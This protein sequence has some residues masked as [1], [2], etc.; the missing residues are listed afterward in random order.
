LRFRCHVGHAYA[1]RSLVDEQ[2]GEVGRFPC[3][4]RIIPLDRDHLGEGD[5][6]ILMESI[7]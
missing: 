2:A 1:S 6:I 4:L 7:G 5:V 3:R